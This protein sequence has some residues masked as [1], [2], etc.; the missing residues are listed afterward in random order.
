MLTFTITTRF[1]TFIG[2]HFEYIYFSLPLKVAVKSNWCGGRIKSSKEILISK[3]R[4]CKE[5]E[6]W[7]KQ[8]D[9]IN[10]H[11]VQQR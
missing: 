6:L 4:L 10:Y 2:I 8:H 1:K 3:A 5:C 7:G 9:K 11:K